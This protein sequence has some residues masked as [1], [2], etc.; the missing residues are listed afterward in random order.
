MEQHGSLRTVL[1]LVWLGICLT[2]LFLV[3]AFAEGLDVDNVSA[4]LLSLAVGGAVVFAFVALKTIDLITPK[5]VPVEGSVVVCLVCQRPLTM[6][7]S[8]A[9]AGSAQNA[10]IS[11][12]RD[13][14]KV[15][16]TEDSSQ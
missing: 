10:K 3:A 4:V 15:L 13:S 2:P 11:T 9:I 14:K 7:W 12:S 8:L 16:W 6:R 5:A 1:I